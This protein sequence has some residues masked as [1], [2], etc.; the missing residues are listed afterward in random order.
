ML[1]TSSML[2]FHSR[3]VNVSSFSHHYDPVRFD[4]LDG[5][6]EYE[7]RA[8]YKKNAMAD[9]QTQTANIYSRES[10][11]A[12]PRPARPPRA[13]PQPGELRVPELT[14]VL[15]GRDGLCARIAKYFVILQR[16]C[17]TSV[18]ATSRAER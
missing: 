9:R 7:G 16:V 14:V 10:N 12:T 3:V 11:R 1:L 8:A 15:Q 17:T 6:G 5:E 2:A 4:N 13:E 18:C